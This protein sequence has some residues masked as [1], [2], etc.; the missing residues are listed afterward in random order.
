HR[1]ADDHQDER[2]LDCDRD[3]ADQRPN[4]PGNQVRDPL[5]VQLFAGLERCGVELVTCGCSSRRT[6]CAPCGCASWN[7]ASLMSSFNL[8][9]TIPSW[10]EYSSCGRSTWMMLGNIRPDIWL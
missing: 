4:R 6:T 7:W 2:D 1:Q 5:L 8:S 3:D 9:L 10:M